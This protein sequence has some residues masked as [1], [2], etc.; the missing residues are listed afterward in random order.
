M[1]PYDLLRDSSIGCSAAHVTAMTMNRNWMTGWLAIL[2]LAMGLLGIDLGL[3]GSLHSVSLVGLLLLAIAATGGTLQQAGQQE[4]NTQMPDR[5]QPS[6]AELYDLFAAIDDVVL[7]L[8]AEGRYRKIAPTNPNN[9]YKPPAE[10]LGKTMHEVLPL[11]FANYYLTCI[12][13]TLA[14]Q[15]II[16][17]DYEL[18]IGGRSMWFSGRMSPLADD[19]VILVARD[20]TARKQT[21]QALQQSEAKH[22]ALLTTLPDLVIRCNAEGVCLDFSPASLSQSS[23]RTKTILAPGPMKCCPPEPPNSA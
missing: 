17:L 21:E 8:D 7:V 10:L 18:P 15:Q 23:A 5:I 1:I 3:E 2:W 4:P 20:I 22:R 19:Q 13:Q 14:Q 16:D 6:E 11:E 12:H 9:L